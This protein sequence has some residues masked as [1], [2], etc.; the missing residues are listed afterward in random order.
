M[1]DINGITQVVLTV[2]ASES[3][4]RNGSPLFAFAPVLVRFDHVASGIINAES[5]APMK[6]IVEVV[7]GLAGPLIFAAI[8][9]YFMY[10]SASPA[11]WDLAKRLL[12]VV[13]IIGVLWFCGIVFFGNRT[14]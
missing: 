1:P 2:S 7:G 8:L 10:T 14:R 5:K 11:F 3:K 13:L 9:G 6:R 12:P 4:P